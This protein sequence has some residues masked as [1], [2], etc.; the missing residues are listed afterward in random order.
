[1]GATMVHVA[2]PG[3]GGGARGSGLRWRLF[4]VGPAMVRVAGPGDGGARG[5][6]AGAQWGL[7]A[8]RG[9]GTARSGGVDGGEW[10]R[11][12]AASTVGSGDGDG[13]SEWEGEGEGLSGT[14]C[15]SPLPSARSRVLDK[16]FFNLKIVF[17]ECQIAGTRQTGLCRVPTDRHSAKHVLRIFVECPTLDTR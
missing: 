15:L 6:G 5:G 2:W 11:G 3:D 10:R 4:R 13:V 8:R 12:A 16:G 9:V 17:A 14:L 7:G 1:M